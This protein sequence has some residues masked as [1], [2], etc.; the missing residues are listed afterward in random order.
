MQ[1]FNLQEKRQFIEYRMLKQLAIYL[2]ENT[3]RPSTFI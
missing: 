2:K 1:K 3:V